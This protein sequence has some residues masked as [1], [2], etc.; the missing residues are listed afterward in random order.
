MQK[1]S[2]MEN[3]A[4]YNVGSFKF[5]GGQNMLSWPKYLFQFTKNV[6]IVHF[7]L[8]FS[9]NFYSIRLTCELT[10]LAKYIHVSRRLAVIIFFEFEIELTV[11]LDSGVP[12]IFVRSYST[13]IF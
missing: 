13:F 7:S 4:D 9:A 3:Y 1:Y 6:A 10:Y 8:S 11:G 12:K 5:G 2:F